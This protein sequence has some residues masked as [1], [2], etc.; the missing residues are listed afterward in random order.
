MGEKLKTAPHEIA[1]LAV[2]VNDIHESTLKTVDFVRQHGTPSGDLSGDVLKGLAAPL[3]AFRDMTADRMSSMAWT[4][5]GTSE[6][7]NRAAW[8]YHDQEA[9]NYAALNQVTRSTQ[10]DLSVADV[11]VEK[12]GLS[13][14]SYA[15]PAPYKAPE[16]IKLDPPS[17]IK[18][19]VGQIISE[20]AG[21]LGDVNDA[22]KHA[23]KGAWSPLDEALQPI[24]GNWNELKRIGE[25]YKIAGFAF[26]NSAKNLTA[27]ARQVD[28]HWDGKA[29]LAFQ[30]YAGKQVKAMAWEGPVGRTVNTALEMIADEIKK[31]A[32]EIVNKLAEM[33]EKQVSFD[34]ALDFLKFAVKKIP[35]VGWTAQAAAIVDIVLKTKD[36]V[37]KLVNEIQE[38]A[39]SLQTFLEFVSDP[40]SKGQE[41]LND[42][43]S[44]ITDKL[45]TVQQQAS[46]ADDLRLIA[47]TSGPRNK[48]PQF[49]IGE[50]RQPWEDA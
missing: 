2:L 39:R 24:A 4:N 10:H 22:I 25:T 41:R 13:T 18:E 15:S 46:V 32:I 31:A 8:M 30:D 19:D 6:E 16:E 5:L 17:S 14:E 35:V 9:K 7:L 28:D 48:P 44:P 20:A 37:M 49:E 1:G 50:G 23:T 36:L 47:D 45:A 29:A 27:G 21:W 3:N 12:Q 26:E 40:I 43:L 33:L 11:D 34:D 42:K 38:A